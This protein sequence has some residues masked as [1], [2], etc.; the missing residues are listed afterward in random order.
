MLHVRG[1]QKLIIEEREE[2]SLQLARAQLLVI[3]GWGFELLKPAHRNDL[4]EI[5]DDRH[6]QTFAIVVS[7]LPTNQWSASIGDSTLA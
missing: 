4:M 5:M 2:M 7:Q 1:L 3:D 6:G